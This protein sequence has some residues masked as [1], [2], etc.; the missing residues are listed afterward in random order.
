MKRRIVVDKIEEMIGKRFGRLVVIEQADTVINKSGKKMRK[1]KCICDCGNEKVA[2]ED[3]LKR[4]QT[5]SCG[6]MLIECANQ[7]RKA[8]ET[9]N[10]TYDLSGDYGIGIS[11]NNDTKFYFDLEDFD[12]IKNYKWRDSGEYMV[13]REY[14]SEKTLVFMQ[15]IIMPHDDDKLVDHIKHNGYDNRKEFLRIGSKCDNLA[16]R[17]LLKN[18][19]SGCTGVHWCKNVGK[20]RAEISRNK[21]RYTLGFFE[22][23]N[24]A[25]KA[26][27][28]AEEE[29]F[30]QWSF[31]N[32][33]NKKENE[34]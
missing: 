2:R 24:D 4:G 1:W 12:K 8:R 21:K 14:D 33:M 34:Q 17:G 31:D 3:N 29:F 20:W 27:K 13:T 7:N 16:N 23:F 6:C 11:S 5:K 19:T 28:K 26:R 25:V 18:N 10:N 15:D 32:S 22:D 9:P 30:G